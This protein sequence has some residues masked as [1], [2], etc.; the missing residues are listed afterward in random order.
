MDVSI[1]KASYAS[2]GTLSQEIRDVRFDAAILLQYLKP[3]GQHVVDRKN[4]S[5]QDGTVLLPFGEQDP[6]FR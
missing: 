4:G 2:N 6:F 3:G 1:L 5:T